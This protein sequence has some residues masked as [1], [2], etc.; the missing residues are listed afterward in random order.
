MKTDTALVDAGYLLVSARKEV[1]VDRVEIRRMCRSDLDAACRVIGL[2][3]ADNP[4]SLVVA[5]GDRTHAQRIMQASVRVAKLGRTYSYVL[6][7]E[8]AGRII[9]VL[10]A[11]AW[12]KCQMSMGE[13][14]RTTP[15]MIRVMGQALPR[16][17]KMLGVWARHDPRER[18]WHLG[19]IAVHPHFQGRGIGK[20]L[21]RSFLAMVD[22][23]RLP[24]YLET[25]VDKNVA[26]YEQ[27]DFKVIAQEEITGVNNRFMWREART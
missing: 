17:L 11:V 25:D 22:E 19:P 27:F 4:N 5:G 23:Q 10:N 8:E 9:G 21:L 15:S 16:V 20:R 2:A 14:V 13:K 26:L 3:F 7:A 24:A 6:V 1:V 18:H 12:P